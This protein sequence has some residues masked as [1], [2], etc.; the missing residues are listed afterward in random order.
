MK[1]PQLMPCPCGGDGLIKPMPELKPLTFLFDNSLSGSNR[2]FGVF[3]L[4]NAIFGTV[5]PSKLNNDKDLVNPFLLMLCFFPINIFRID[6]QTTEVAQF[7]KPL[8]FISFNHELKSS[9]RQIPLEISVANTQVNQLFRTI[10]VDFN[11]K[12]N[13]GIGFGVNARQKVWLTLHPK[14]VVTS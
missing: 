8:T 4:N 14:K 9:I 6:I 7:N 13:N 1:T 2:S 12:M 5:A 3:P 11:L 10:E